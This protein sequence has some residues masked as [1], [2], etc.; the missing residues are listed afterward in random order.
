M[1]RCS[2]RGP[3]LIPLFWLQV[4]YFKSKAGLFYTFIQWECIDGDND[5][6]WPTLLDQSGRKRK[7]SVDSEDGSNGMHVA[8]TSFSEASSPCSSPFDE[9]EDEGKT[10]SVNSPTPSSSVGSDDSNGYFFLQALN[11]LNLLSYAMPLL[12]FFLSSR[13]IM[14]LA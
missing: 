8:S 7:N 6:C 2:R 4:L 14:I 3:Y 1:F 11:G 5:Q 12:N 10:P 9:N 13:K